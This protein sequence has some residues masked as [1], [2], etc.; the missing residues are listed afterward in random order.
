MRVKLLAMFVLL[1]AWV[2]S[3]AF[4]QESITI[5]PNGVRVG[6]TERNPEW[7][8]RHD[9]HWYNNRGYSAEDWRRYEWRR[10]HRYHHWHEDDDDYGN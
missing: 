1:A 3:P 4:A 6:P 7:Y 10:H 5:S 8:R 2:G 9:Y